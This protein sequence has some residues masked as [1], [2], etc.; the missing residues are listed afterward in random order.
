M[1]SVLQNLR[2]PGG[3]LAFGF[4]AMLLFMLVLAGVGL[5][6]LEA[7]HG[8]LERLVADPVAKITLTNRMYVAA[9]ERTVSLQRL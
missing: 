3:L 7:G 8:R 9:R 5:I 1:R 6:Q 4:A 2:A